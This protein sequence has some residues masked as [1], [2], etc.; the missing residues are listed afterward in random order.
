MR[1][2]TLTDA[3]EPMAA[4]LSLTPM[5]AGIVLLALVGS[6]AEISN[7]IVFAR[8]NQLDL[9][10]GI[11]VGSSSLQTALFVAPVLVFA[12]YAFGDHPLDLLFSRPEIAAVV[13][14]TFIALRVLANGETSW[15]EGVVV[16][17]MLGYAF[18]CVPG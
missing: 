9:T 8:R 15:I 11:A 17:L 12:S 1:S 7:A 13:L 6:A 18:L 5:C 2:E 3:I 4:E 16:Y 14:G 10:L